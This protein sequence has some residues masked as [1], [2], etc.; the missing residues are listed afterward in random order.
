MGVFEIS[1]LKTDTMA[2]IIG[3]SRFLFSRGR[4]AYL[5]VLGV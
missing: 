1:D 3:T 5:L 2:K 4:T